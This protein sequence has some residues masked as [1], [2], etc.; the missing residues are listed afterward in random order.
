MGAVYYCD[1]ILREKRVRL[2]WAIVGMGRFL[3][4]W[5]RELEKVSL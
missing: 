3:I 5:E 4:L 2:K 1:G